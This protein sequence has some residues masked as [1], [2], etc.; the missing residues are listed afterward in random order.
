MARALRPND[1][2]E[3]AVLAKVLSDPTRVKLMAI[4][5]SG[6]P[7]SVGQLCDALKLPQPSVSHHLGLLRMTWVVEGQR[8]GKKV[9][10]S[11]HRNLPKSAGFQT[12]KALLA[13]L[14]S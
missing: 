3:A 9:F 7:K 13:K 5:A 8:T 10:Y 14:G 11:V 2:E 4:L 6:K 1:L 12:L